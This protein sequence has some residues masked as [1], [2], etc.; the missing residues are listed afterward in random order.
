MNTLLISYDLIRPGQNYKRLIDFIQ[1]HD[2]WAKPLESLYLIKSSSSD[3]SIRDQ[4][5]SIIDINDKVIVINVTKD[6]AVWKGLSEDVS[7]WIKSNL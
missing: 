7:K 5:T 2:Y 6:S 4:I 1:S 3:E